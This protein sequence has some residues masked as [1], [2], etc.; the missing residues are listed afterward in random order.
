MGVLGGL[1][2]GFGA[3][4]QIV[5]T[6]VLLLDNSSGGHVTKDM[7]RFLALFNRTV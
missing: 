2:V 5:Q 3:N 7:A 4:M 6:N 1:D